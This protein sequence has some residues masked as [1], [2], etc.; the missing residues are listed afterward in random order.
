MSR[1]KEIIVEIDETGNKVILEGVGFEGAEC[2]TFMA[3]LEEDL[4]DVEKRT[5]KPEYNQRQATH[6]TAKTR[7]R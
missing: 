5:N 6:A 4:G 7:M 1:E 2:D 3:A